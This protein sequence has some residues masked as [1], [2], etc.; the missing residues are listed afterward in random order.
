[1]PP[2]EMH[3]PMMGAPETVLQEDRIWLGGEVAVGEK[4][5]LDA[6][7][8]RLLARRPRIAAGPSVSIFYVSHIDLSGNLW[9]N[10]DVFY[11]IKFP[12]KGPVDPAFAHP[13][14]ARRPGELGRR[15]KSRR[16]RQREA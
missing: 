7:A 16:F 8:H 11:D 2:D 9:Y 13:D 3:D 5:Q 12:D 14:R 1:M 15:R 4:Q 6:F 10:P